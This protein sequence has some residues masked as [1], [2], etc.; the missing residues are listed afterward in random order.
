MAQNVKKVLIV[1]APDFNSL[2]RRLDQFEGHPIAFT[3]YTST[4]FRPAN[5]DSGNLGK[6]NRNCS[7]PQKINF[8]LNDYLE[9][10]NKNLIVGTS[11]KFSNLD[12]TL[13]KNKPVVV[14]L[15]NFHSVKMDSLKFYELLKKS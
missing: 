4:K 10:V 9:Y 12:K 8:Y 7:M 2:S 3:I 14:K 13:L 15:H 1:K 11:K 6:A 5:S